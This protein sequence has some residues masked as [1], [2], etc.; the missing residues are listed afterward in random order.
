VESCGKSTV[1]ALLAEALDCE[2]LEGDAYH[3]PEAVEKM[4][5]GI[6]LT[7]DDRWP[8]LDRI[9][10]ALRTERARSGR[11]VAACSALA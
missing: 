3:S 4:K 2:F 9:A 6:P 5:A 1:G 10:A 11:V 7:D 8:W